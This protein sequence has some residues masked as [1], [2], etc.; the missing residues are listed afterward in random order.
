MDINDHVYS[1][2]C[3]RVELLS[4][5]PGQESSVAQSVTSGTPDVAIFKALGT[6]DLAILSVYKNKSQPVQTYEHI[7]DYSYFVGTPY[8]TQQYHCDPDLLLD[9]IFTSP[10]AAI[11]LLK[12]SP[13]K[14]LPQ[15]LQEASR[16]A[17]KMNQSVHA[18]PIRYHRQ[19]EVGILVGITNGDIGEIVKLIS[20][21]RRSG[22]FSSTSTLVLVNYIKVIANNGFD[23]VEGKVTGQIRLMCPSEREVELRKILSSKKMFQSWETMGSH[24]LTL[25]TLN[26]VDFSDILSVVVDLRTK[27]AP[28]M[29]IA[30][31][32]QLGWSVRNDE[33]NEIIPS[34]TIANDNLDAMKK[35][36]DECFLCMEKIDRLA[37]GTFETQQVRSFLMKI[38]A[39]LYDP[40][41]SK[42][43]KF[44]WPFLN[45]QILP[46]LKTY[47]EELVN[48][49]DTTQSEK[50]IFTLVHYGGGALVQLLSPELL[51]QFPFGLPEGHYGGANAILEAANKF[52]SSL[53]EPEDLEW[54]GT[55]FFSQFH[56]FGLYPS[57]IISF[58]AE[59]LTKVLCRDTNWLTA[60]HEVA[61][62]YWV[63]LD[64]FEHKGLD[65]AQNGRRPKKIG[66]KEIA[67]GEGKQYQYSQP[68]ANVDDFKQMLWEWFAHWFDYRHFYSCNTELYMWSIWSSWLRLP[69]VRQN[70]KEYFART[71]MIFLV[72]KGL[73]NLPKDANGKLLTLGE[74][75]K[76]YLRSSF[77]EMLSFLE[78]LA[79]C[80]YLP[81]Y[82][83]Q[84]ETFRTSIVDL[85]VSYLGYVAYFE[86]EFRMPKLDSPDFRQPSIQGKVDAILKGKSLRGEQQVLGIMLG[87]LDY[88]RIAGKEP[89]NKTT[90]ALIDTLL[91]MH[92]S[93]PEDFIER[94]GAAPN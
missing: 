30:T 76:K 40:L 1:D 14:S 68:T 79:P 55:V 33:S 45:Y 22:D 25:T 57:E 70:L 8:S 3:I 53:Y 39:A 19:R 94:F 60:T 28:G 61:H 84:A 63:R 64:V 66:L 85:M 31:S 15:G 50:D 43:A 16:I 74:E 93:Q 18:V 67:S 47:A 17:A 62:S 5:V 26:E 23:L 46:S 44:F 75:T 83:K 4:L 58:P 37:K 54:S 48:K 12:P 90:M 86:L 20:S 42:Q 81:T 88:F 9:K 29:V 77:G 36:L 11:V 73:Q 52:V 27:L 92:K 78:K 21:I 10:L 82:S 2:T 89:D 65:V 69:L 41:T 34:N 56:N 91:L 49:A 7:L 13:E 80:G 87:L 51:P 71:F 72:H 6:H 38:G 32:T 24:D 35:T 59:C